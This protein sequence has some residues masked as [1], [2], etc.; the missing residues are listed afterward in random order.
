MNT[1]LRISIFIVMLTITS[2]NDD[3]IY[4]KLKTFPKKLLARRRE[5]HFTLLK[6]IANNQ[7]YEHRFQLMVIGL[8]K[9]FDLINEN[10]EPKGAKTAEKVPKETILFIENACLFMDFLVNFPDDIYIVL[11]KIKRTDPD[12]N[13]KEILKISLMFLEKNLDL[14]DEVTT[15]EYE[16]VKKNLNVFLN[17]ERLWS[18]PLENSVRDL[19]EISQ[20]AGQETDKF[21][22][23]KKKKKKIKKGPGLQGKFEL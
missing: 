22:D 3:E 15:K 20:K 5:E 6:M 21:T 23:N 16:F 17:E 12:K 8:T 1:W 10:K 4:N 2:A 9:A 13:W 19:L 7:K 14:L 11:N 18:Y